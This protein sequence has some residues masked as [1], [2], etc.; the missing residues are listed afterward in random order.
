[1]GVVTS[2]PMGGGTRTSLFPAREREG[3]RDRIDILDNP[4]AAENPGLA[5]DVEQEI[6]RLLKDEDVGPVEVRFRICGDAAEGFK[7]ICK[8]ENRPSDGDDGR[9]QWRW[10]SPLMETAEDFRDAFEE[11]LRVRRDRLARLL[12]PLLHR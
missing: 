4:I 3:Q 9:V 12:P 11:G 1:M 5:R 6:R 7:F 2:Q 10:W 8:V